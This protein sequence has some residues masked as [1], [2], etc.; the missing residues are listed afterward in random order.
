MKNNIINNQ[1]VKYNFKNDR[2]LSPY[3]VT[4]FA[5]AES[6]F[7]I[8]I[9]KD[10]KRKVAWRVSPIFS[11]ELHKRDLLILKRLQIFFRHR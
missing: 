3:W 6:S 2:K 1:L 8:R 7:S 10:K 9:T 4:G 5:D 11:I